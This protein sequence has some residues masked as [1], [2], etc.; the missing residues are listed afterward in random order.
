MNHHISNISLEDL[1]AEDYS[2]QI[3]KNSLHGFDLTIDCLQLTD[4]H[5]ED[6]AIHPY[7]MDS[8][9]NF[10]EQFLK[11]YEKAKKLN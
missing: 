8:F 6:G 4:F 1:M 3:K 2:L 7:A 5:V 9:A 10:C 11:Q